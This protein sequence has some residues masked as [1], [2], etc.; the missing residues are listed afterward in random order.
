LAWEDSGIFVAFQVKLARR[1]YVYCP[2]PGFLRFVA[3]KRYPVNGKWGQALMVCPFS[4]TETGFGGELVTL[5][6][7]LGLPPTFFSVPRGVSGET[8]KQLG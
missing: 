5:C 7:W 3:K 2:K 8:G 6:N 4:F 1:N